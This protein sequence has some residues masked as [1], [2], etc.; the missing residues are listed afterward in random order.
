MFDEV[1][2]GNRLGRLGATL[3]VQ[4]FDQRPT[5]ARDTKCQRAMRNMASPMLERISRK[6]QT[7]KTIDCAGQTS[8]REMYNDLVLV[9]IRSETMTIL[10]N[11]NGRNEG[12]IFCSLHVC[13][14]HP[15][16]ENQTLQ[17]AF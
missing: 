1:I 6:A 17:G 13:H 7:Y 5:R 15:T 4:L 11:V 9:H 12:N 16:A 14:L 8:F 2:L 3:F 10:Y